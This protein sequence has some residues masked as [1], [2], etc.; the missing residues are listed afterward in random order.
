MTIKELIDNDNELK[1]LVNATE[2]E[3]GSTT[4]QLTNVTQDFSFNVF[5]LGGLQDYYDNFDI[6]SEVYMWLEAKQN[7]VSGVPN[8]VELVEEEKTIEDTLYKLSKLAN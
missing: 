2:E 7:G 5:T 3:D 6:D 1:Y 8:V 4:I